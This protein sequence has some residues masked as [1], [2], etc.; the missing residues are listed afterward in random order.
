LAENLALLD[1]KTR[2][3]MDFDGQKAEKEVYSSTLKKTQTL[4]RKG[5]P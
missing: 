4:Q 1:G 5:K 2:T 3:S